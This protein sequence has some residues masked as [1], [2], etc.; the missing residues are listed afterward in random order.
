[1]LVLPHVCIY[2]TPGAE[3]CHNTHLRT[4]SLRT[5]PLTKKTLNENDIF[6]NKMPVNTTNPDKY[7]PMR[8]RKMTYHHTN[9]QHP[10]HLLTQ[11]SKYFLESVSWWVDCVQFTPIIIT[12]NRQISCASL[13]L[14]AIMAAPTLDYVCHFPWLI[15][16]DQQ[17][18]NTRWRSR[19]FV[20]PLG[21]HTD[22]SQ[23]PDLITTHTI[24]PLNLPTFST[25]SAT[26]L[27]LL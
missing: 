17:R 8:A 25:Q 23:F 14:K 6:A 5:A 9:T 3:N 15:P 24:T 19:S 22:S 12:L 2:R 20:Q 13:I 10:H 27:N 16:P 11:F 1:M 7:A 21:Y 4:S 26:F 18:Q